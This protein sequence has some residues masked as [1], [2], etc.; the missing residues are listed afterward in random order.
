MQP[1]AKRSLSVLAGAGRLPAYRWAAIAVALLCLLPLLDGIVFALMGRSPWLGTAA[2]PGLLGFV[3]TPSAPRLSWWDRSLQSTFTHLV[4][5]RLPLRNWM[6]R[7][8]NRLDYWFLRTSRMYYGNIVIGRDGVLFERPYIAEAFG[9]APLMT[10]G[11]MRRLGTGLKRMSDL[12]ARRH[13]A[14]IVLGTP[15]KVSLRRDSVPSAYI[16]RHPGTPRNYD[17]F[18]RLLAE[19]G[20]PF[21]DGRAEL[22]SAAS[23]T[24]APFFPVGGTHW[25]QFGAFAA[26]E[27]PI[28]R[29]LAEAAPA[30][31]RL[32]LDDVSVSR[33][34][35][36]DGDLLALLNLLAFDRKC[37]SVDVKLHLEGPPLPKAIAIVGSSFTQQIHSV[38]EQAH[39]APRIFNFWY[40]T[41][42]LQ[43]PT[44]QPEKLPEGWPQTIL[45]DTSALII[46]I[47]ETAFFVSS[48]YLD[49][50]SN[51]LLPLLD[52][53]QDQPAAQ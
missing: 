53:Q 24:K 27:R 50:L 33:G 48:G 22:Q 21:F 5:E 42:Y 2:G 46:E 1:R 49:A 29:I 34:G 11:T 17:R 4:D 9:Y 30:P 6:V 40:M 16:E 8:N 41:S 37:D 39:I 31:G 52:P 43:C 28:A 38:L 18:A 7:L 44:C 26:L 20:V 3:Q 25:T 19:L 47:N 15:G 51:A 14:M 35:G 45:D 13:I 12:L 23:G 36:S 32:V 10:E